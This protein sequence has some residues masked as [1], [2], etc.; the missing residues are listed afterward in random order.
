MIARGVDPIFT[1]D[2]KPRTAIG[3]T[4]EG[5][6]IAVTVDGG[7]PSYGISDGMNLVEMAETMVS[8]GAVVA[9]SLDGG[10]STMMAVKRFGEANVKIVNRPSDGGERII[11]NAILFA[12]RAER[13]P[14]VGEVRVVP[15]RLTIYKD[16]AY[17]F[18]VK[19]T[20][21]SFHPLDPGQFRVLWG[22]KNGAIGRIDASGK[23][24]S[25]RV[26]SEGQIYAAVGDAVGSADIRV[27]EDVYALQLTETGVVPVENGTTHQFNIVAYDVDGTPIVIENGSATW[28][29]EGDIGTID[30]EGRF[31]A[32]AD[33]QGE[34]VV[35]AIVGEKIASVR[36]IVGMRDK[37]ID[38]FEHGEVERYR[39]SGYVGGQGGNLEISDEQFKSGKRSL[40]VTYT[41]K[42]WTQYNGT[43]NIIPRKVDK[44]G[45]DISEKYMTTIRPKKFGMWVYG[46]GKA[47]WLRVILTDGNGQNRTYD[48][49]SRINWTGWRYVD[50]TI[51]GD[52][53][54]PISLNYFYMVETV[55]SRQKSDYG[56][57]VYFDDI[58]FVYADDE[59]FKPPTF[60][61]FQPS[62]PT[63]YAP[64][65]DIGVTITDDRSGIDRESVR[66]YLDEQEVAYQVVDDKPLSLTIRYA[67]RGL[68]EGKHTVR[69]T[70]RDNAGNVAT[71]YVRTFDVDLKAQ[72]D[73]PSVSDLLPLDGNR[74][75]TPTPRISAKIQDERAGVKA[76]DITF[77]I[78]GVPHRPTHYDETSGIAYLIPHKLTVGAHHIV[79]D[80]KN[81]AG[82]A[83]DRLVKFAPL[84][85]ALGV[86]FTWNGQDRSVT[87][88]KGDVEAV[89]WIDRPTAK[90]NGEDVALTL[91]PKLIGGSTYVPLRFMKSIFPF[92]EALERQYPNGALEATFTVE[93][94]PEP[95]DR[96]TM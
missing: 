70:A 73:P 71:P 38:D 27:V 61:N 88:R 85:G 79:V 52:V 90:V 86:T 45:N 83:V 5:K 81:R 10:G 55:Q 87:M 6:V 82:I 4:G 69:V 13:Q 24:R 26:A 36:V 37:V 44:N 14:D 54:L 9:L 1:R 48:L 11:A 50:V 34:G 19:L 35:T 42:Y 33:G 46:D 12:T 94:S 17:T 78:N 72:T 65:V 58:R 18:Q 63:V 59:D 76:E 95:K 84:A 67:A 68:A 2:R 43:I 29:V 89:V 47:P 60:V 41:Y 74:L 53:P 31:T 22:V 77:Y 20:D 57:T 56:G 15:Q 51:P 23:F 39:I 16:T 62:K 93:P 32:K 80:A 64:D 92:D 49:A 40:K 75:K 7:Q 66:L 28:H 25:G 96:A 21:Q 3:I 30:A 91:A 8:L